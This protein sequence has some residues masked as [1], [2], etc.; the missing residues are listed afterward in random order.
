MPILY[1]GP[2]YDRVCPNWRSVDVFR[3]AVQKTL[4]EDVALGRKSGPF[5]YPP[6]PHFVASPLGAFAKKRT[7]KV[8]VIHDLSWPPSC[9]VNSHID[10][11]ASSVSYISIDDAVKALK[12]RGSMSLM[13]KLDLR[14][15]YK[16]IVVRPE[17]WHH[18]GSSWKNEAGCTEYY[19][20]HV[21]PF[22][23]RSSAMLFD[24]FASGLEFSMSLNG[25]SNVCHYLD[26]FFTCGAA[27]TAECSSNLDIML[28]T[29]DL[30][31]MPVNPAKVFSPTTRL[32]FLGIVLDSELMEL[33]M[34]AERLAD[35]F[36]ELRRWLNNYKGTKRE[37][38]SLL[39]KLVYLCRII[40]PGRIFIRRLFDLSKTVKSLHHHVRLSAE[41]SADVL[42]WL[43]FC[44]SWNQ[45]SVFY[46]DDWTRGDTIHLASDAS[47]TGIG[48]ILGNH[49]YARI[50]TVGERVTSIAFR[51]LLAVVTACA[52]WGH[53]LAGRRLLFECD[54][55]A[56]V[57][58]VNSGTSKC[59]A[60]MSLIRHLF[61]IAAASCFDIR[62][63]HVSGDS[64]IAADLLSRMRLDEF[65]VKFPAA[66]FVGTRFLCSDYAV[67]R[68]VI[69]TALL[70]F[71]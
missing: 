19:V 47:G 36:D 14:D 12:F 67:S 71:R 9:S 30:L 63:V 3:S 15:A 4:V 41:A 20:D 31:G 65:H 32:E 37:L 1:S 45:R 11:I 69:Y 68:F 18:L 51:E 66:D 70:F 23:M 61:Y 62:M 50:L 46:D 7:G 28:N 13:S 34:S 29:C 21:L 48:G 6:L 57:A 10:P 35:V 52:C 60:I 27:S 55:K 24:L 53:M 25:C 39:G 2:D 5:P 58:C 17:D 43:S 16:C 59:S 42:W 49:W 26:D 38:L 64:N 22:G 8:R 33:Q 40:K 54:N 56:V 44:S